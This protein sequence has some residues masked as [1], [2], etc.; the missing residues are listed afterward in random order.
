MMHG[1]TNT[2]KNGVNNVAL[3]DIVDAWIFDTPFAIT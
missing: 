2:V 3:A 1:K